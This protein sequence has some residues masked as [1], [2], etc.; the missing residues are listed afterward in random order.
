MK[1][2][3]LK[4][5]FIRNINELVTD[6]NIPKKRINTLTTQIKK[7]Y[8]IFISNLK[9][10]GKELQE[11]DL[12]ELTE[13]LLSDYNKLKNNPTINEV[14]SQIAADYDIVNTNNQTMENIDDRKK[15]IYKHILGNPGSSTRGM[16]MEY[17][18]EII[19]LKLAE[20]NGLN[21]DEILNFLIAQSKNMYMDIEQYQELINKNV[22]KYLTNNKNA[23]N[24][25]NPKVFKIFENLAASYKV[26]E[27]YDKAIE[28][29]KQALSITNL[30]DE[31]D[32]QELKDNYNRFLEFLEMK[33]DFRNTKFDSFDELTH[34]LEKKFTSK[35]IFV[36]GTQ[37][38]NENPNPNPYPHNP[39]KDKYIMP[40]HLKLEGFKNLLSSLKKVNPE[41]D[42]TECEI[43][44]DSYD[45]YVIFKIKG[46]NV[47]ILENFSTD[48]NEAL[49]IVKNEQIDSIRQLTKRQAKSLDGVQSVNHIQNFDNYCRNLF[50]KTLK[51]I[52]QTQKEPIPELDENVLRFDIETSITTNSSDK[53]LSNDQED[54]S[55]N[56]N[57]NLETDET[58]S[59]NNEILPTSNDF[60]NDEIENLT[61]KDTNSVTNESQ[62][63]L[64]I[65]RQKA[66]A[67]R[68]ELHELEKELEELK[69]REAEIRAKEAEI[70]AKYEKEE[71]DRPSHT[72]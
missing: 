70:R 35:P 4:S 19:E 45:G 22:V 72:S 71:T 13:I 51:S 52:S 29:Y 24:F 33:K 49:F 16:S 68:K 5:L 54:N 65:E 44:K 56:L 48:D 20:E 38:E 40:V 60:K 53:K 23:E 31:P 47:S 18:S 37:T 15:N 36:K 12:N 17:I 21:N 67:F 63:R 11:Y 3:E 58:K 43:G 59:L 66:E 27:N 62:S 14:L 1:I 9:S 46:T 8:N 41:F 34:A 42:I 50:K 57:D 28:V 55:K 10:K 30:K 69:K 25:S 61:S 39:T 26:Q 7:S 64:E 2:K 32:Y 6:G